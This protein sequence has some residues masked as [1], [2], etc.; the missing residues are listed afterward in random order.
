MQ[1]WLLLLAGAGT[2]PWVFEVF[3]LVVWGGVG[4]VCFIRGPVQ[5]IEESDI[6]LSLMYIGSREYC[7][8]M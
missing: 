2:T 3:P 8:Q 4:G 7:H 1:W 6:Y 5:C